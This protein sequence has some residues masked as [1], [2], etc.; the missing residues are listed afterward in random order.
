MYGKHG[1]RMTHTW[2]D[3]ML[4][5]P[6]LDGLAGRAYMSPGLAGSRFIR[7]VPI[8]PI[9]SGLQNFFLF[10]G[11][12]ILSI[13]YIIVFITHQTRLYYLPKTFVTNSSMEIHIFR[14]YTVLR[15]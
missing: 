7:N 9:S 3:L 6:T 15:D 10:F 8:S 1:F 12:I 4:K 13:L 14:I 11:I 5:R 2:S